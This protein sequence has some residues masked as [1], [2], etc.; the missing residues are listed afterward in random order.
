MYA[1]QIEL[2]FSQFEGMLFD[3]HLQRAE[4]LKDTLEDLE[5]K[6]LIHS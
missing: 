3:Q 2:F 5:E 6:E 1:Q 4:F